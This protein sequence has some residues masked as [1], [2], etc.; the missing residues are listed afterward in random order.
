MLIYGWESLRNTVSDRL[1][2]ILSLHYVCNHGML[3]ILCYLK[4]L[5]FKGLFKVL[6]SP[7][8]LFCS[9][10]GSENL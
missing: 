5:P 8:T 9:A 1:S 3:D 7:L 2:I 10:S 6:R 4:S